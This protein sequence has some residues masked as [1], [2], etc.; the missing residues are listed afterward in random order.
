MEWNRERKADDMAQT[1]RQSERRQTSEGRR[2]LSGR[3]IVV[4]ILVASAVFGA[5]LAIHQSF[6][7]GLPDA[8]SHEPSTALEAGIATQVLTDT[9]GRSVVVPAEPRHVAVM[10]SFCGELCIMLG[11]GDQAIGA[12]GG[13]LGDEMLQSMYPGLSDLQQLSG[14]AVNVEELVRQGCDLALVKESMPASE[15]AKLDKVGIPY[16]MVGYS[17]LEEQLEAMR[18]V[19]AAFG[20]DAVESEASIRAF[21]DEVVKLVDERTAKIGEADRV[22]VYHSIAGELLC[23]ASGSLGASW[24]ERAGGVC[25]SSEESPT[26][27][28][29]YNATLEQI[30]AWNPDVLVFS[31]A[32]TEATVLNS[33]KWQGLPAVQEGRTYHLPIGATRWGHRG[34]VETPLAMLWFGCTFFPDL[35]G[36]VD[37]ESMVRS[38]YEEC[39]GVPVDHEL[40][41]RMFSGEGIRTDGSGGGQGTGVGNGE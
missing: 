8:D 25:V 38:Y 19:A 4:V 7:R 2:R 35:Y 15:L 1:F 18:L 14:N 5:S 13:I 24:I 21:Y 16:I 17:T 34:S 27:G 29:D 41:E 11:A 23:D 6:V 12:P 3:L 20:P 37:M 31:V 39:L 30:Y 32:S 22:R 36:D 28:S 26:S 40:Y 10:D 33:A 9:A